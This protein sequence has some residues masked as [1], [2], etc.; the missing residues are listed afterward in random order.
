[1]ADK[2]NVALLH[3]Q[4]FLSFVPKDAAIVTA[5]QEIIREAFYEVLVYADL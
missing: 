2:V 1:M 3:G 5:M 4:F